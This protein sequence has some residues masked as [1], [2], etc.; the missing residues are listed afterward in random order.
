[1]KVQELT[2]ASLDYWVAKAIGLDVCNCNGL[3]IGEVG[4]MREHETRHCTCCDKDWPEEYSSDWSQCGP[5]T[6]RHK[7]TYWYFNHGSGPWH[8]IISDDG[9]HFNEDDYYEKGI[10]SA[11]TPQIAICRCIVA[12]KYG[13]EVDDE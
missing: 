8:A 2:G 10:Q 1:M 4:F 9:Q 12:S 6:E 7:I 3:T 11:E 13:D 5:L